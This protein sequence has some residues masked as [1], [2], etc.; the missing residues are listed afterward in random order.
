[1]PVLGGLRSFY[2]TPLSDRVTSDP[3]LSKHFRL[4]KYLIMS[5]SKG[6][7]KGGK[8]SGGPRPPRWTLT[9]VSKTEIPLVIQHLQAVE[10]CCRKESAIKKLTWQKANL[11]KPVQIRFQDGKIT[12]FKVIG[13]EHQKSLH[14][15]K[16]TE[17]M[18]Y[19]EKDIVDARKAVEDT[20]AETKK[21]ISAHRAAVAVYENMWLPD[22]MQVDV[23]DPFNMAKQEQQKRGFR[24]IAEATQS[25]HD[26]SSAAYDKWEKFQLEKKTRIE[27]KVKEERVLQE[28][29][30][31]DNQRQ[32]STEQQLVNVRQMLT[33][34]N[35]LELTKQLKSKNEKGPGDGRKRSKSRSTHGSA[36][37]K[38]KSS[39]S[40]RSSKQG[41]HKSR[42]HLTHSNHTNRT[43]STH[44]HQ[45]NRSHKSNQ[46]VSF[47]IPS[48][49]DNKR[50]RSSTTRKSR[51]P[52]PKKGG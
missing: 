50:K 30:V 14:D 45:S 26:K 28:I 1:M 51:N 25:I 5:T 52:R 17:K 6:V 40:S 8:G 43:H 3:T 41:S 46:S 22:L 36:S 47:R 21:V 11:F 16:Y 19:L 27:T 10:R 18:Q 34:F 29:L 49:Q 44:S 33:K 7:K 24:Q 35:L 2:T 32:L 9:E 42:S 38:S 31:E 15:A 13:E 39:K 37:A 48:P 23:A 4:V 20:R 12:V